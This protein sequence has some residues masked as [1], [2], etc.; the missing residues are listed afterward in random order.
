MGI[1]RNIKS[2]H[3]GAKNSDR[4]SGFY[5]HRVDA[6]AYSRKRRRLD[7]KKIILKG[8]SK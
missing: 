3:T 7:G 4:K 8:D 6:K 1:G 5:G 2:E